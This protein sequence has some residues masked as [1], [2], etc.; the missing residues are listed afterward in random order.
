M[1]LNTCPFEENAPPFNFSALIAG[2]EGTLAFITEVRL[3]LDPL[4]PPFKGLLCIHLNTLEEALQANLVCLNH[5]PGAVELMDST[6]LECTKSNI[7]QRKN[8][9]FVNGDPGAILITEFTGTDNN[10]I[11]SKAKALESDLVKRGLGYYFP[12][13][14]GTDISKVWALQE[15]RTRSAVQHAR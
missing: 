5:N 15:I 9:F 2:S 8:R 6:I 10:E 14:T 7:E 13:V 3:N 4:P 12:L 1:L 11:V